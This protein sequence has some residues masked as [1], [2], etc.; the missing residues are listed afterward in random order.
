MQESKIGFAT[1]TINETK[2]LFPLLDGTGSSALSSTQADSK[3]HPETEANIFF[4]PVVSLPSDFDSRSGEENEDCMFMHRAK[5]YRY[6]G[7]VKMWKDRGIGSIKILRHK[8]SNKGRKVMRREQV[9][10]LCC[11]HYIVPGMTL[12]PASYPDRALMDVV[13]IS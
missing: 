1:F 7:E 13:Y 9:L 12:K 5:L 11:N 3:E 10:K 8:T 6:D 4:D 2:P